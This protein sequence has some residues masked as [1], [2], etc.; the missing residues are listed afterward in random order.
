VWR[1]RSRYDPQ[2]SLEAWVLTIARRRSID[3]LRARRPENVPLQD[4]AARAGTDG[5]EVA[6]RVERARDLR[7]LL[8]QL[9]GPQREAIEM[10]YFA[11]LTQRQ[12]A[13]QLQVPLGTIKARTARGLRSLRALIISPA[14]I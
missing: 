8:A 4:I 5:R 10:A 7:Q 12:I 3:Y 13:D 1:H 9:P 2:R 6:T 11:D 14:T